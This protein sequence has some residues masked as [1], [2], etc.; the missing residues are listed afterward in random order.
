MKKNI[1]KSFP[2]LSPKKH[3]S[4]HFLIEAKI[5]ERMIASC[6]LTKQDIV[7]EIGPGLGALTQEII[8]R[9]KHLYTVESDPLLYEKLAQQLS[10]DNLTMFCEDFLKINFKTLPLLTKIIGNLP[11][12]ISTPI[13]EKLIRNRDR[14]KEAFLTVQLEFAQR[15]VAPV[16][17]KDYG[18]LTC[19]VQYYADVSIL[20]KISALS[21]RPIPKVNS[22]FIHLNFLPPA[23]P[24]QNEDYLSQIIQQAFVLRRKKIV[25]SLSLLIG[26]GK[27]LEIL[28]HLKINENL[29][30]E[31]LT[32]K[33]YI[34]I[35]N[36]SFQGR[37]RREKTSSPD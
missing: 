31:N 27:L 9:V 23:F 4:Q 26:K 6:H 12:H 8:K 15:L 11:Y 1:I 3:L 21:F 2:F 36:R 5:K 14:L 32:L 37:E 7:L 28:N 34:D 35:A 22:C 10:Q 18:A 30:A 25:N 29:R 33:N 17:S 13:L 19:F 24:A 20:F 16:N